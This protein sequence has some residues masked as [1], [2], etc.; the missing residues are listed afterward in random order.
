MSSSTCAPP[1]AFKGFFLLRSHYYQFYLWF[2]KHREFRFDFKSVLFIQE[3]LLQQ[4][5][6]LFAG[7]FYP[8]P[9][10]Q[11]GYHFVLKYAHHFRNQIKP[12]GSKEAV[13]L[14]D[15]MDVNSNLSLSIFWI[16]T[17]QKKKV[18]YYFL[19]PFVSEL[20][21]HVDLSQLLTLLCHRDL[22]WSQPVCSQI[23]S[24]YRSCFAPGCG[25]HVLG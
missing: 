25:F 11:S 19:I 15:Q 3:L 8:L 12:V 1:L 23:K 14:M 4:T 7:G 6:P 10:N 5:A 9:S 21:E 17:D 20:L 2:L 13:L 24:R 18:T 16:C 22:F